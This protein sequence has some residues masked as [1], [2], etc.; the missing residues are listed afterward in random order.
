MSKFFLAGSISMQSFSMA[1]A[2]SHAAIA[3]ALGAC[4]YAPAIPR[5]VWVWGAFCSV[6]PDVDVIGFALGVNY[7]DFWGH[8]GFT[9]SLL[10]AALLATAVMLLA[11]RPGIPG[12][13][14]KGLWSYLFLAT[15]SHGVLDALTN[16]GLG[17]AFFSPFDNTRYFFPY[18]PVE[19]SPIGLA[20]FFTARGWRVLSSELLWLWLPA[21][22]FAALALIL[23]RARAFPP[24][25]PAPA[26]R[27]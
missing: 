13:G 27:H 1:S 20:S 25:R 14:K 3:L 5:R 18:T 17:I 19:V 15:A 6:L 4:Y 9:H 10:F 23:R 11:F 16:G 22:V 12:L 8:R 21:L 7:E 24:S 26:D 2:F